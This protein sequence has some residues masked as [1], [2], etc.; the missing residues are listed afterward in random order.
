MKKYTRK[1][2]LRP[3]LEPGTRRIR[4]TNKA[5]DVASK[6]A[7]AEFSKIRVL[8]GTRRSSVH[9]IRGLGR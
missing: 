5:D 1:Q 3:K 6:W 4:T 2:S 9:R 7:R 8:W